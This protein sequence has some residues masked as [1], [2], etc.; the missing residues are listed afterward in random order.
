[1]VVITLHNTFGAAFVGVVASSLYEMNSLYPPAVDNGRMLIFSI[2]CSTFGILS[3]QCYLYYERYPLDR[4]F[5]KILVRARL[6]CRRVFS[7]RPLVLSIRWERY[8]W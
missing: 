2:R 4:R 1:M 3:M 7:H 8:G 5:Y 6:P